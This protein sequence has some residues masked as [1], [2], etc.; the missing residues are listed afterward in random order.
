MELGTR[1]F[2][3]QTVILICS[4]CLSWTGIHKLLE[5]ILDQLQLLY[6]GHPL[7]LV[8][9]SQQVS[10]LRQELLQDP[11]WLWWLVRVI[12]IFLD[13]KW[14]KLRT[15]RGSQVRWDLWRQLRSVVLSKQS[16]KVAPSLR[17]LPPSSTVFARRWVPPLKRYHYSSRGR[18]RMWR[19]L[20]LVGIE[21]SV[22][23]IIPR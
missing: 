14:R 3:A 22:E 16:F 23:R 21:G 1:V 8:R 10:Q 18:L 11:R 12:S 17:P 2:Q 5:T 4:Q 15:Q 20:L 7:R 19:Y 6:W 13:K 9:N